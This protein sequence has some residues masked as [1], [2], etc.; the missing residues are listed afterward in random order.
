MNFCE[1]AD[2]AI[3]S[4][5]G[6]FDDETETPDDYTEM[7]TEARDMGIPMVCA[8]PDVRA[9]RGDQ[10]IYCGG[11]L[12]QLYEKLGG[13]TIY[14]GKP[15]EPIYRLSRA[16]LREVTGYDITNDRVLAIGDNTQVMRLSSK[17]F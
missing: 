6:L 5:T 9:K 17:R 14:T 1:L 2:A 15:H 13:E 16:W 12:A 11:A 3:I 4:C 10:L 7:L 8:N